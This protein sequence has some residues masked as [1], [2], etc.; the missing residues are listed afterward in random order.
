[1]VN[2]VYTITE[3]AVNIKTKIGTFPYAKCCYL[4][5]IDVS[6]QYILGFDLT[7]Q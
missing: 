2:L 5:L 7:L 6:Y 1:M 4:L 3:N